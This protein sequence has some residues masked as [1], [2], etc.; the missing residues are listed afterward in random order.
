MAEETIGKKPVMTETLMTTL[1]ELD[2]LI[3]DA[4]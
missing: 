2:R 4:D 1:R 3:T